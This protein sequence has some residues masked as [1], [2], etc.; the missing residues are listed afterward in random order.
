M[1]KIR[2]SWDPEKAR[3]NEKKH[4]VTFEEAQTVFRDD[5]ARFESDPDHSQ[6]E[7]RFLLLGMSERLRLLVVCHCYRSE[8]AEIRLISA[9]KATKKEREEYEEFLR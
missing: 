6:D 3:V 8:D 7:D 1:N 2:F 9:R 5:N 4:R